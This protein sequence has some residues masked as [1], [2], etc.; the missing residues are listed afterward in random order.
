MRGRVAKPKALIALAFLLFGSC[1]SPLNYSEWIETSAHTPAYSATQIE[2]APESFVSENQGKRVQ[3][4]GYIAWTMLHDSCDFSS[5]HH[6]KRVFIDAQLSQR[7]VRASHKKWV[8]L[9]GLVE[10]PREMRHGG[11]D[12]VLVEGR[13]S[14]AAI[15]TDAKLVAIDKNRDCRSS[16]N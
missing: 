11:G 12:L 16:K 5:D 1:T 15:L 7:E 8:V 4:E 3:V 13:H 2:N 10:A 14:L 6:P 9:S